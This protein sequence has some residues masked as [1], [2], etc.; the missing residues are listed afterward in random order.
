MNILTA[1]LW[2]IAIKVKTC[3]TLSIRN[4]YM[5]QKPSLHD[6]KSVEDYFQI[7]EFQLGNENFGVEIEQVQDIIR[8]PHITRV[9]QSPEYVEGII[10]LR[11]KIIVIIDLGTR[12]RLPSI[13]FDENTSVIVVEIDGTFIGMIVN[14][15]SK[16]SRFPVLSVVP[17][18]ELIPNMTHAN[19]IKGICMFNGRLLILLNLEKILSTD[20]VAQIAAKKTL[21]QTLF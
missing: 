9:P 10:N 15:V 4:D 21:F 1:E 19:Y 7:V 8:I 6:T 2:S 5:T 20:E 18:P 14:S 17:A 16:V 11:E 12:L 3:F 13:D